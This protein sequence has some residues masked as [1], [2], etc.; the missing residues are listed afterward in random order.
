MRADMLS[1][2]YAEQL[3][4]MTA[5]MREAVTFTHADSPHH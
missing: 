2:E 5:L 3:P 4:R 1:G